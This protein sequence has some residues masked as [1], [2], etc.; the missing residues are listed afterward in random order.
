MDMDPKQLGVAECEE[1]IKRF[2]TLA[3]RSPEMVDLYSGH[4][5]TAKSDIWVSV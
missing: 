1:Q 5:I 3:Y 2:T 4:K